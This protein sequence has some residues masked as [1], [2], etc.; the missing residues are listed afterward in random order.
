MHIHSNHGDIVLANSEFPFIQDDALQPEMLAYLSVSQLIVHY[1]GDVDTLPCTF[2]SPSQQ[3]TLARPVGE[4]ESCCLGSRNCC[5]CFYRQ[6]EWRGEPRGGRNGLTTKT[7]H[8][9]LFHKQ[10]TA[11]P[12]NNSL[13][14]IP[15]QLHTLT[16]SKIPLMKFRTIYTTNYFGSRH[17]F[18]HDNNKN[19]LFLKPM[20]VIHVTQVYTFYL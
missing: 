17:T 8:C 12:A 20:C 4:S 2:T 3:K 14:E 7:P 1:L 10:S 9:Q 13:P 15:R 19:Y 5:C 16:I 6:T 11:Y 18:I